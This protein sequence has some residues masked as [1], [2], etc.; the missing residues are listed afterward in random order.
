MAEAKRTLEQHSRATLR[1][2]NSER[3]RLLK[4]AQA[5]GG[6]EAALALEEEIVALGNALIALQR[7]KLKR[8]HRRYNKLFSEATGA[9]TQARQ[10]LQENGS[11]L[12][13]LDGIGKT[14]TL[15]GRL[16]LLLGE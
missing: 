13:L 1:A 11:A 16:L 6:V 4:E 15:L 12:A 10:V 2:F 14:V 5:T 7:A 3:A 9:I 8:N